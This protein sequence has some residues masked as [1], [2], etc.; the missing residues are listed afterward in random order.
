M[1]RTRA[2]TVVCD[3]D[4][5]NRLREQVIYKHTDRD[6]NVRVGA[7]RHALTC[8]VDINFPENDQLY[9][10]ELKKRNQIFP[11]EVEDRHK[12]L[13]AHKVENYHKSLSNVYPSHYLLPCNEQ[14]EIQKMLMEK[15][16]Q[17]TQEKN[18]R[19]N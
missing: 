8:F 14:P 11:I 1:E 17:L 7:D 18:R 4:P 19:R 15:S 9:T 3:R 10:E 2:D 6:G 5:N 13:A 12:N 16:K